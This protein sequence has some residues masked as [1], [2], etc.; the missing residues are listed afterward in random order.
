MAREKKIFAALLAESLILYINNLFFLVKASLCFFLPALIIDSYFAKNKMFCVDDLPDGLF[1]LP[2]FWIVVVLVSFLVL[3]LYYLV[4]ILKAIKYVDEYKSI[5]IKEL[6]EESLR[7][8]PG[9]LMVKGYF[10][11]NVVLKTVMFIVP[12]I[13]AMVQYGFSS[14]AFVIDGKQKGEAL[15]FSREIIK[16]FWTQYLDNSLI[17][18]GL[19]II[20]LSPFVV[21]LDIFIQAAVMKDIVWL[22]RMIDLIESSS[23]MFASIFLVVFYYCLYKEL[24]ERYISEDNNK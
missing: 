3:F 19:F 24:K 12:G 8:F 15:T 23:I 1:A 22:A 7:I 5:T 21:S 14:L 16:A 2:K 18:L 13:I 10:A 17:C 9:Y 6:H 11:F 20:V 4:V